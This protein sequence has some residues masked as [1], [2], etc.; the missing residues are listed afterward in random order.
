MGTTVRYCAPKIKVTCLIKSWAHEFKFST[1]DE[2]PVT[3]NFHFLKMLISSQCGF[4]LIDD[5]WLDFNIH[6]TKCRRYDK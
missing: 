1:P 6:D 3:D 4:H 5:E 2:A